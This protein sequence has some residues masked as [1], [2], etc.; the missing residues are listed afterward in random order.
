[1]KKRIQLLFLF[2]GMVIICFTIIIHKSKQIGFHIKESGEIDISLSTDKNDVRI[3]PWWNDEEQCFYIFLP[4]FCKSSYFY[5]ENTEGC[6]FYV[7]DTLYEKGDKFSFNNKEEYTYE[8]INSSG[9]SFCAN[10]IFMKSQNIPSLYIELESG[11]NDSILENKDYEESAR[12]SIVTEKGNVEYSG[13]VE[14]ISGRGN[15]TWKHYNKKSFAFSLLESKALCGLEEGKDWNLLAVFGEGNRMT[16]KVSMDI[17]E[18]MGL[19]PTMSNT[20]I[21]VFL[22]GEY[23]GNY[24]LSEAVKVGETRVDI[25]NLE[26]ENKQNN[27]N[28]DNFQTFEDD[29][30]KGYELSDV[31][32]ITGG[33]LIEKDIEDYFKEEKVG[34][35]TDLGNCFTIKS[36]QHASREQVEYI[37]NYVNQIEKKIVAGDMSV[38]EYIDMVSFVKRFLIDEITMNADANITSM[39]FYKDK[40]DNKLYSGPIWDCDLGMGICNTGWMEGRA[41]NYEGSVNREFRNE[42][43]VWNEKLSENNEFMDAVKDEYL[44]VLPYMEKILMEDISMYQTLIESSNEMDIVRWGRENADGSYVDNYQTY[45]NNVRHMRYFLIYRLNYLIDK[46]NISY[47][48]FKFEGNGQEHTV[49]Y[50][51]DGDVIETRKFKDGEEIRELP[52]LDEEKYWGWYYTYN[53]C[54]TREWLPVLEDCIFYARKK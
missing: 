16:T 8:I 36:P 37:Y 6:L 51:L 17:S 38:F 9:E 3:T 52:Y 19:K 31:T 29:S 21:D 27:G 44:K 4:S 53:D 13:V 50:V 54:K 34:F 42:R 30:Y 32:T 14:K 11:K 2:L 35:K 1:M 33:F 40:T 39:Y 47:K 18:Y 10:I 5:V 12:V 46:W 20:W 48:E 41:V 26:K 24:L 49:Q 45:E 22:N 28:L 25:Y 7:E 15:S 43:L 23:W